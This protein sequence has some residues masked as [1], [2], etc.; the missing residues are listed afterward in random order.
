MPVSVINGKLITIR[1]NL[2]GDIYKAISKLRFS[3]YSRIFVEFDKP[4]WC[5]H[6]DWLVDLS[7]G[8]RDDI[9]LWQ[10]AHGNSRVLVGHLCDYKTDGFINLGK[11]I[12]S[13]L[14]NIFRQDYKGVSDFKLINLESC[15]YSLGAF[16]CAESDFNL[17]DLAALR[18]MQSL[19]RLKFV[20]DSYSLEYFGTVQ[21]AVK[22]GLDAANAI[23]G[24]FTN[25]RYTD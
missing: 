6:Y 20:G 4:D 19:P 16:P 17:G 8:F 3:T 13:N 14:R 2:D 5:R 21:G 18:K 15:P 10:N 24:K 22:S 1:P 9:S 23:Y 7:G 12:E 11:K 25:G